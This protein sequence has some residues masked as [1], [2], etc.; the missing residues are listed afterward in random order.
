[1]TISGV[2]SSWLTSL[3]NSRSRSRLLC[4]WP[5]ASSKAAARRP[6]SSLAYCG[7]SGRASWSR[8]RTWLASL[9]MGAITRRASSQPSSQ[10]T[11]T[12]I[13]KPAS[14]TSSSARS[15]ASISCCSSI[16]R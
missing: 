2:R 1:M 10:A 13:R 12:L 15:R 9:V 5:M 7:A 14:T 11:A 8:R 16:S 6:T 4:S 3:V